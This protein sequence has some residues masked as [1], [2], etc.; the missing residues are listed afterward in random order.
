MRK[1]LKEVM[2]TANMPP[3]SATPTQAGIQE[4]SD[5]QE[6]LL[7]GETQDCC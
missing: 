4:V 7:S 6:F 5:N 3:V 2:F 1:D